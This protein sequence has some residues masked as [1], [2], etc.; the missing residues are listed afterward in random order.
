MEILLTAIIFFF[1]GRYSLN[2]EKDTKKLQIIAKKLKRKQKSGPID[3]PT[4]EQEKYVGSEEE[5]I[6]KDWQ[7]AYEELH[8]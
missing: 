3:F 4:P 7:R 2:E 8:G 6:D 5:K 1:L